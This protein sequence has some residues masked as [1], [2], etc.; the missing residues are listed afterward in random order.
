MNGTNTRF[1]APNLCLSNT[2]TANLYRI[3]A[4]GT[5]VAL[6]TAAR[7]QATRNGAEVTDDGQST[8]FVVKFAVGQTSGFSALDVHSLGRV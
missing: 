7:M 8:R 1:Y 5:E 6:M 4:V 2:Y 3:A